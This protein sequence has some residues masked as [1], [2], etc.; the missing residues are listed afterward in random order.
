MSWT[1]C[2]R[3]QRGGRTVEVVVDTDPATQQRISFE[4]FI[5]TAVEKSG[6][7]FGVLG[8]FCVVSTFQNER[9][10][11]TP[12]TAVY[13]FAILQIMLQIE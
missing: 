11:K 5:P 2:R 4:P 6:V 13:T 10:S 7:Y 8:A 3:A 12:N 1:M 9:F